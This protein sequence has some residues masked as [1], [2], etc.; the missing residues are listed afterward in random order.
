MIRLNGFFEVKPGVTEADVRTLSDELV[1]LS[2][3][4]EG[5]LS[6]D[7]MRSTTRPSVYMFCET[8]ASAEALA[9][10]S[11]QE[12]FFRLVPQIKALT[13]GGTHTERFEK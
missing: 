10:H 13:I 6:Y 9:A 1:K 11:R 12:H 2:L 7:L 5:N 4:D 8:W 3:A